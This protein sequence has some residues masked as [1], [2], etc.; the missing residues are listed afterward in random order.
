V[1][2]VC[3][4]KT[5]LSV[6]A[7]CALVA[8][9]CGGNGLVTVTGKVTLDG[10]PLSDATV[11]FVPVEGANK[12]STPGGRTDESGVFYLTTREIND[13]AMPGEYNVTVTKK[14]LPAKPLLNSNDI[15]DRESANLFLQQMKDKTAGGTIKF[16]TPV[17]YADQNK[18]PFRSVKIP[19]SE[20]LQ[21]DLRSDFKYKR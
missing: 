14:E 17:D 20:S 18:T 6:V 16:I 2:P 3:Y 19:P 4:R 7:A 8:A 1:I 15:K 9:G 12:L 21:F 5:Y 11:I 13:G 10:E